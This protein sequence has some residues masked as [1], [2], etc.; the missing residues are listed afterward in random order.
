MGLKRT[1]DTHS[2]DTAETQQQKAYV[3]RFAVDLLLLQQ[4]HTRLERYQ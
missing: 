2:A 4:L 1:Q 3:S